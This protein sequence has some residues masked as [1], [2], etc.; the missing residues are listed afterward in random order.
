MSKTSEA[1]IRSIQKYNKKQTV[2]VLLRLN[3]KPMPL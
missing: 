3:K 1:Q 2:T